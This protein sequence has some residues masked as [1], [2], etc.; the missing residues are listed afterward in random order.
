M[1]LKRCAMALI[2]G[3]LLIKGYHG[4]AIFSWGDGRDSKRSGTGTI[5]SYM[6]IAKSQ[7][8]IGELLR[9]N[10]HFSRYN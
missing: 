1:D 8:E 9:V 3:L 2:P 6:T 5:M 7:A 10:S 4:A